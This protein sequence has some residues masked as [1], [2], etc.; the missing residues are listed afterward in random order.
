VKIEILG[1][2]NTETEK[3]RLPCLLVDDAIALD[4]GA[5]TSTLPLSR[6]QSINKVLLTHHH[7][8]HT[9]DL[10][11]LAAN[12]GTPPATVDVY[13]L[14][15]TLE[16]VYLY[17]FDGNMY[18]DYTAWPSR[19]YPRIKLKPLAPGQ[20]LTIGG[21]S[22]VPL[23]VTHSVP[24]V[25]YLLS[26][27]N[28]HSIFYTGDTGDGLSECWQQIAPD[29]LFIE[30][31]GLNR[32]SEEMTSLRRHL[33]PTLLVNELR[34]FQELKGYI[35]RVV[36]VHIPTLYEEELRSELIDAGKQLGMELEMGYEGLVIEV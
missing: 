20:H 15:E 1:A 21:Y 19:E 5:L 24:S 8:D 3:Y 4:A 30:V 25:G 23:S 13:G 9:R 18:R 34:Q 35:P 33:T 27:N 2:H 28:G 17:H 32:M 36:T 31:A 12:G 14:P 29:V 6:Q 16:I 11:I 7:F 10:I 22:V 26:S